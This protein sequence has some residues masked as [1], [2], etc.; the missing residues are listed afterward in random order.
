MNGELAVLY[1]DNKQ[2]GGLYNWEINITSESIIRNGWREFKVVKEIT[3]QG[4]WLLTPPTD[5]C[6]EIKFYKVQ[7]GCLVL[8]G[9]GK[10]EIDLP[11]V[12]VMDCRLTIPIEI[13]WLGD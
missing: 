8:I 6:F 7:G 10:A 11:S 5:N 9:S 4:Y 13:R 2:S 1:Q 3:A 12:R